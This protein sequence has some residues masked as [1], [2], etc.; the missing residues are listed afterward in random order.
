[1]TRKELL[2]YF[3]AA[4]RY[5]ESL[6]VEKNTTAFDCIAVHDIAIACRDICYIL[7][8]E[9]LEGWQSYLAHEY[10]ETSIHR[11]IYLRDQ[12]EADT[13]LC[14]YDSKLL[15]LAIALDMADE[16]YPPTETHL[17]VAE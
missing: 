3:Q 8:L 5:A 4:Q 9:Q 17:I 1:M 6:P 10:E 14:I 2:L 7:S 15:M 11:A 13:L 12:K 16:A